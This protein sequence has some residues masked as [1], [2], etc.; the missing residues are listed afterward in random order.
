VI[1][2]NNARLISDYVLRFTFWAQRELRPPAP[3]EMSQSGMCIKK[4]AYSSG[5]SRLSGLP[6]QTDWF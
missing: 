3:T 1:S 2:R 6:A 4:A 5:A